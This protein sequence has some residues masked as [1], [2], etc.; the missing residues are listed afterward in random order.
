M[1]DICHNQS[2]SDLVK[3]RKRLH[4][5]EARFYIQQLVK[6]MEYVHSNNII[7]RDLK[8]GNLFLTERMQLKIGDF[9]LA[10][11]VTYEGERKITVC[12]TPNYLAPEILENTNGHSFEVDFWSIGVILYTMLCGKPPFESAEVKQTYQKIKERKFNFPEGIELHSL[13]KDFIN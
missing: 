3:R 13:A 10:A 2:L 9:G 5:L 11:Q 8:L 12:G 6:G 7:H 4:E 1:L